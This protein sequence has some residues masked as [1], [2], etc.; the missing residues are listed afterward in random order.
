MRVNSQSGKGGVAYLMD[1]E[2]GLDLPRRLQVEFSAIVQHTTE[3]SGTE[4][5]PDALW[6]LFA[7]TY[8]P[9]EPRLVLLSSEVSTSEGRTSVVAQLTVA[10]EHVT[11][12]GSGNGPIDALLTG[13]E[14][15]LGITLEV[16]DYT[17]HALT[18]GSAASAVAYVEAEAA[19]GTRRW[20]VGM[21][22]SILDA[23]LRA[24]ISVANRTA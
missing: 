22:S 4:I 17:Q 13:L 19:D 12:A 10:G 20:G 2:H 9:E 8:L 7:D 16:T 14:A 11:V 18:S 24:V 6:D 3:A 5:T 21:D 15:T 23:S 1:T